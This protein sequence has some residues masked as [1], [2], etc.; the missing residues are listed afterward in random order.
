MPGIVECRHAC[1]D[2]RG[3]KTI[4]N[5]RWEGLPVPAITAS[6]P[7]KYL[8]KRLL[9]FDQA[10]STQDVAREEA[11]RGALEGTLV[12]AEEQSLGRGRFQ[13]TWVSPR[14]GAILMSLVLRP[15]GV[16]ASMLPIVVSLATA[17]AVRKVT[18]LE[19]VI[20]WPNDIQIRGKKLAGILIDAALSARGID[21]AIV[22]IGLNV[23]MD[24]A[25]HPEITAIATSLGRETGR[26]VPRLPVLS[27]MLSE[28]ETLYEAAKAGTSM[29][30][31]WKG[32]LVTLGQTVRVVWPGAPLGQVWEEVGVA[33]DVDA[34]GALL[35][36]RPDGT[37]ATL[38]GGEVSLR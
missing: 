7:T 4:E 28:I 16:V 11:I 10:T 19:A 24:P 37:L 1:I 32:L 23:G 27:A 20:K 22:G 8:G 31:E 3:G 15:D 13:R 21:Y 29:V 2:E 30:P 36:R 25:A 34:S 14:G 9:Y 26:S 35:L 6:L 18:G 17:L 38:S 12:L 33:E 5:A